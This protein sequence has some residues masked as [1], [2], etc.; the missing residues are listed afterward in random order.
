VDGDLSSHASLA[1]NIWGSEIR[2]GEVRI[3]EMRNSFPE[4]SRSL[5]PITKKK[6]T[7]LGRWGEE[8]DGSLKGQKLRRQHDEIQ[9]AKKEVYTTR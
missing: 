2:V 3:R 5:G 8:R 6:E 1:K 9:T 4:S 7:G